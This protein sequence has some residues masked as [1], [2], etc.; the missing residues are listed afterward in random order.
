ML[1]GIVVEPHRI[2]G[3][4]HCGSFPPSEE[5][6]C[7]TLC[8]FQRVRVFPFMKNKLERYYGRKDL[9]FITF[10]CY[11]RKA[12]LGSAC[13]RK[14]FVKILAETRRRHGF[15][16]VGYEAPEKLVVEQLAFL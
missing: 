14:L 5:R 16:L 1:R 8:G 12:L 15:L 7:R 4:Y 9:H 10:R 11:K 2:V 13:G 3:V 6:G